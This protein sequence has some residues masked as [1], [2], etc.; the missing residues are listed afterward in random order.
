VM[1]RKHTNYQPPSS[2]DEP[3][4]GDGDDD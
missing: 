1:A 4:S 3:P 2:E